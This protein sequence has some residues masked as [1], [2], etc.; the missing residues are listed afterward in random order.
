M[1]EPMK[2]RLMQILREKQEAWDYVLSDAL[3]SEYGKSGDYWKLVIRFW[4]TELAT[5][6]LFEIIDAKADEDKYYSDDKI[7]YKYSLSD[8]GIDTLEYFQLE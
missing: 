1:Q 2:P 4:M 3:L 5:G 6:G 7:V 8:Y